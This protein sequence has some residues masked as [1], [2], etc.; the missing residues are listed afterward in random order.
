MEYTFTITKYPHAYLT[1]YGCCS[2]CLWRRILASVGLH[3]PLARPASVL[4][5]PV[6]KLRMTSVGCRPP[7]R[8]LVGQLPEKADWP[9]GNRGERRRN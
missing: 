5:K 4:L 8:R 7:R 6:E 3:P 1:A 2:I 9:E